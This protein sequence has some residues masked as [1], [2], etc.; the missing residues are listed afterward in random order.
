[1]LRAAACLQD[2]TA[3]DVIIK[4]EVNNW[5]GIN[6]AMSPNP[7]GLKPKIGRR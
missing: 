7:S 5:R 6:H 3:L 4:R 2:I 1:L